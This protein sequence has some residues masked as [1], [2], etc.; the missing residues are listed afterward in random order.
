VDREQLDA[1]LRKIFSD[2]FDKTEED[3]HYQTSPDDV[4]EWDS[5][6]HVKLV[7]SLE[8]GFGVVIPPE[9]Q[10]DMLTFELVGDILMARLNP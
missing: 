7:N 2:L 10:I 6:A 9:D 4:P 5:L 3:T 8:E 1:A